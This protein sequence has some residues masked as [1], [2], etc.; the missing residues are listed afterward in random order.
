MVLLDQLAILKITFRNVQKLSLQKL[1]VNVNEGK[2]FGDFFGKKDI[3]IVEGQI[4]LSDGPE[5]MRGEYG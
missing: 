3:K 5:S 1:I 2:H 4:P